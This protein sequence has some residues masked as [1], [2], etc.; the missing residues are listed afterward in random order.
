MPE[1]HRAKATLKSLVDYLVEGDVLSSGL[2]ITVD[3]DTDLDADNRDNPRSFC[4]VAPKETVIHCSRYIER[5]PE[6]AR[7]GVLLHEIAHIAANAFG[8][9]ECEVDADVWVME[10]VPEANYHYGDVRFVRNNESV[11]ARNLQMVCNEF[12]RKIRRR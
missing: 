9:D 7:A 10:E 6:D 1:L 8:E 5:L 3:H 2:H 4:A 12:L 11:V